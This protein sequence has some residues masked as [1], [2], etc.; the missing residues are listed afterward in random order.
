MLSVIVLSVSGSV[1]S[2]LAID[3]NKTKIPFFS[4]VINSL[5][6]EVVFISHSLASYL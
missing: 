4:D 2:F 3:L 5:Y 6:L 1:I